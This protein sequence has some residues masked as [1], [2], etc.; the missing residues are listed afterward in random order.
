[1]THT[2]ASKPTVTPAPVRK[3]IIVKAEAVRAFEVFTAGMGRWWPGSH[4]IGSSPMKAAVIEPRV[5]GRW[6]ERGEDGSECDWGRVLAWEPP[7]RVV[8]AWQI[9]AA[10]RFDPTLVTEVEVRFIPEG[11]ATRVELEHRDIERFG[12]QAEA[13]RGAL[14]SPG[15]WS[16]LLE[17]FAAAVAE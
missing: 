14:D 15:G 1:M 10:W 16:G 17:R 12:D 4:S 13:A 7:S 2:A 11:N 3:S 9:D 5:G 8:L 6:F